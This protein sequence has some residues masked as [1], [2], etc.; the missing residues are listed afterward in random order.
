M[1]PMRWLVILSFLL[2]MASPALA[3]RINIFALDEGGEVYTESTFAGKRPVK[4]GVIRVF[5]AD[6]TQ[7]FT[8]KTDDAGLLTFPRP[9]SGALTVE[10]DAGMGHKSRWELEP[11]EGAQ[12]YK[13]VGAEVVPDAPASQAA[14][15]EKGL[16]AGDWTRLEQVVDSAVTRSLH[17]QQAETRVRD[18]VGGLGY[19]VGLL[20]AFAWYRSRKGAA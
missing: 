12:A 11:A 15:V 13:D 10:V 4:N 9:E 14:A 18:V 2:S 5:N 19:I 7:V 20:G 16:S 17:R 6:G 3:H 1:N 8:G